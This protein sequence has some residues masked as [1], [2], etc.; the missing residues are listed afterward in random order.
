MGWSVFN[1]VDPN[2]YFSISKIDKNCMQKYNINMTVSNF[3]RRVKKSVPFTEILTGQGN[4][5][6][7]RRTK[8]YRYEDFRDAK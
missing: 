4:I 7:T 3:R 2:K 6:C 5:A 1:Q 8:I